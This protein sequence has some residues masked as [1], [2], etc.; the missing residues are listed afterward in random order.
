MNEKIKMLLT[1][2]ASLSA[3]GLL[4]FGGAAFASGFDFNKLGVSKYVTN[5]YE[6]T[7]GF[8]EISVCA[9]TADIEFA[10]SEDN[11]CRVV[12]SESEKVKYSAAVKG[13]ALTIETVDTRKWYEYIVSFSFENPKITVYLPGSEYS[14]LF[15]EGSTGDI[16]IPKDFG[17]ETVDVSVTTGD[18]ICRAC[19]SGLMKIKLTTGS[20]RVSDASAGELDITVTTGSVNASHITCGRSINVSVTTGKTELADISCGGIV[21]S[22]TTGSIILK[23]VTA[24]ESFSIKRTTGGV[25]FEGSDAEEIYV[26]TTTGTVKGTLLSEK[27]FITEAKTG[28]VDVPKTSTGGRCEITTTTGNIQIDIQ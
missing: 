25:I 3:V 18:V 11:R 20:V 5:T 19:A 26:K 22:G 17:F 21:S 23:N 6:I 10:L 27:I 15:I 2:A 4:L 14:S 7:D 28:S 1:I 9:D 24:A 8:T 13:E 12:C 16:E